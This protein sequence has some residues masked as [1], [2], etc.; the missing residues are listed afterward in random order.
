[1]K[2]TRKWRTMLKHFLC[3]DV[4]TLM[5]QQCTCLWNLLKTHKYN[6]IESFLDVCSGQEKTLSNS[7]KSIDLTNKLYSLF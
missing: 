7:C 6:R 4:C 1:M 5:L 3:C 2:M